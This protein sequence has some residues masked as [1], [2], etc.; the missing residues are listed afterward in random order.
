MDTQSC[1]GHTD[2]HQGLHKL[3]RSTERQPA[4]FD[5]LRLPVGL[6]VLGVHILTA[7]VAFFL[8]ILIYSQLL[9]SGFASQTP[10]PDQQPGLFPSSGTLSAYLMNL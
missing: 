10:A 6:V 4:H 7:A 9:L 1:T 3:A 5:Q 2:D 8:F